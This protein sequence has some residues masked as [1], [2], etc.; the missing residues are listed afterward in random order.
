MSSR[1]PITTTTVEVLAPESSAIIPA[2]VREDFAHARAFAQGMKTAGHMSVIASIFLGLELTKLHKKHAIQRG[3]PNKSLPRSGINW[4]S[5]LEAEVGIGEDYARLLMKLAEDKRDMV[6][7][8]TRE[9]ILSTPLLTMRDDQREA[10][11]RVSEQLGN[12]TSTRQLMLALG[13]KDDKKTGTN[14]PA[15]RPSGTKDT[16]DLD[17]RA[18]DEVWAFF[19]PLGE[20]NSSVNAET[21]VNILP[22]EPDFTQGLKVRLDCFVPGLTRMEFCALLPCLVPDLPYG[23]LKVS[24]ASINF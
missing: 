18:Q 22:F 13:Y 6:A 11:A 17:Q 20:F 4:P 3:R 8:L 7:S 12:V 9:D 23:A 2:E 14:N 10:I 19:E 21:W 24:N 16:R 15:G 5:V 1:T